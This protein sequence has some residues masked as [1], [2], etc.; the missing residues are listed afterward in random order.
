[1]KKPRTIVLQRSMVGAW[2]GCSRHRIVSKHAL[3]LIRSFTLTQMPETVEA[4]EDDVGEDD[5]GKSKL[6]EVATPWATPE[7][8]ASW[9][10]GLNTNDEEKTTRQKKTT[11]SSRQTTH[12]LWGL[13]SDGDDLPNMVSKDGSVGPY[14]KS[15][16]TMTKTST[17]N[18]RQRE[19]DTNGQVALQ[20]KGLTKAAANAW[21]A[22]LCRSGSAKDKRVPKAKPNAEQQDVIKRIIDRCL[23]EMAD[24]DSEN[25]FRSEPLRCIL[26]GIPGAGKS[27]VLQWLRIFS[28]M[29]VVGPMVQNLLT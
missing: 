15:S 7:N 9:I 18:P 29:Y 23:Q 14:V 16:A 6:A 11:A 27:E 13:D 8:I 19:D 28:K 21:F 12:E 22:T 24:E 26:H 10:D 2:K 5:Q 4:H 17:T 25:E 20:Y 3:K 1:M